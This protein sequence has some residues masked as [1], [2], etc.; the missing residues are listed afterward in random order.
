MLVGSDPYWCSCGNLKTEYVL[1][2][3][4]N[5]RRVAVTPLG[6]NFKLVGDAPGQNLMCACFHTGFFADLA[7]RGFDQRFIVFLTAG[8][9]LPEA[10]MFGAF[11]QQDFQI[12]CVD[13][14]QH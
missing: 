7:Q 11:K 14:N 5:A 9:G 6:E 12:R 4:R 10:R 13:D 2:I 3:V 8:D 1:H